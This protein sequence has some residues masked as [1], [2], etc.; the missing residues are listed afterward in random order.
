M[1]NGGSHKPQTQTKGQEAAQQP[2]TT[3]KSADSKK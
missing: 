3:A 1:A 2:K